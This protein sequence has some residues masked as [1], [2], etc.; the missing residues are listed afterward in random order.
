MEIQIKAKKCKITAR[1][2]NAFFF[3][4]E[5]IGKYKLFLLIMKTC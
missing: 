3:K 4:K 2:S 5:I 1:V